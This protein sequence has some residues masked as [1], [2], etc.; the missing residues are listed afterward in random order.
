MRQPKKETPKPAPAEARKVPQ[1][2]LKETEDLK[3]L[4]ESHKVI[5]AVNL[6]KMPSPQLQKI[7]KELYGKAQIRIAKKSSIAH[8]I[9]GSKKAG[10]AKLG[11]KIS[12]Q[13]GLIFSNNNPFSLYKTIGRSKSPAP[14][15]PGQIATKDIIISAGGTGIA[16]GPAIGQLQKVG[17]KTVIKD[18]KIAI[19][20]DKV[21]VKS[22]QAISA[23]V[24]SVLG[25][26]NIKPMEI[27]LD[28]IAAYEDGTVFAK[29]MLFVDEKKYEEDIIS[30]IRKAI[31]LSLNAGFITKGTAELAIVKAHREAR[32]LG[33][34]AGVL[35]PE[36]V[37]ELI[38][39]AY[40][41]AMSVKKEAKV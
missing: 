23:E 3:R 29:D 7:K 31:N 22:G 13:A 37:E 21:V 25:M 18:G 6:Y 33:I 8:A 30:M 14:A 19:A 9:A 17:L 32:L 5:G 39:K 26:L 10:I 20:D 12:G 4:I 1:Y 36:L 11:D 35:E 24:C 38:M 34:D 2:K 27:G 16:A 28:M 41:Q 40:Q 15:K